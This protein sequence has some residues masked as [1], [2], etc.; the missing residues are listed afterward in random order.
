MNRS[1]ALG[2]IAG[3]FRH[4]NYRLYWYGIALSNVGR[5]MHTLAVAW[6]TWGLTKSTT[7]LGAV[8]F[9]ST[10]PTVIFS[11]HA[12]VIADR[13]G[14]LRVTRICTLSLALFATLFVFLT[15]TGLITPVLILVLAALIGS[16]LAISMPAQ[17]SL[18]HP[19][20][21]KEDISAAIAL[22]SITFNA[23]RFVGPF[24]AEWR[25]SGRGRPSCCGPMRVRYSP[26]FSSSGACASLKSLPAKARR[27][28]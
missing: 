8:G 25:W 23:A 7:W 5:W 9:A 26:I 3:A 22:G 21:P 20:V 16:A 24:W 4:R 17:I 10:F 11:L 19:L 1:S 2:G 13:L 28:V 15:A 27:A 18:V 14:Y 12:G 6:L